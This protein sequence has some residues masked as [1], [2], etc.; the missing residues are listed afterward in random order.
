MSVS[1]S[2]DSTAVLGLWIFGLMTK[3]HSFLDRSTSCYVYKVIEGVMKR[4]EW[5]QRFG[6]GFSDC[7]T[8]GCSVRNRVMPSAEPTSSLQMKMERPLWDWKAA[9]SRL[10]MRSTT[11]TAR[12]T[13]VIWSCS[14]PRNLITYEVKDNK[15]ANFN[16][17]KRKLQLVMTYCYDQN[18]PSG[19][20]PSCHKR[21]GLP[22]QHHS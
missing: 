18:I 7:V 5:I 14:S 16:F 11:R 21:Q 8:E 3:G 17:L 10:V 19:G 20:L 13:K 9:M 22:L 2:S 6:R 15:M 1:M 12:V 4:S